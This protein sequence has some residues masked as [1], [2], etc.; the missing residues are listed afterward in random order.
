LHLSDVVFG[1][2]DIDPVQHPPMTYVHR[3][4]LQEKVVEQ[5]LVEKL[6]EIN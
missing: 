5:E 1:I 4:G 3:D 2:G 6:Q